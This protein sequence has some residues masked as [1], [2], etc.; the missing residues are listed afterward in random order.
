MET[1]HQGVYL[2]FFCHILA[3]HDGKLLYEWLLERA[4]KSGIGGGSA[5]RAVCGYGRHGVLHEEAFFE[6]ADDLPVKVEFLLTEEQAKT[7]LDAVRTCGVDAVY[8]IA[9]ASFGVLG[10][11]PKAA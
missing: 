6:L 1:L 11:P 2:T 5:F 4:K 3:R 7:L 9:P 10:K 8:A